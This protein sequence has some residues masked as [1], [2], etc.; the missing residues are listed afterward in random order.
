MIL[1]LYDSS[2]VLSSQGRG[3]VKG[4]WS[5]REGGGEREGGERG[6]G[7]RRKGEGKDVEGER[8]EKGEVGQG[9]AQQHFN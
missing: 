9:G 4:V 3:G 6:K 1:Q 5:R 8:A 2:Q 7:R